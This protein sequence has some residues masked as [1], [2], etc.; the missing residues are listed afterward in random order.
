MSDEIL[1][2]GYAESETMDRQAT[3]VVDGRNYQTFLNRKER[4]LETA[5]GVRKAY[6]ERTGR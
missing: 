4:M 5:R 2:F 3:R 6:L 1:Y